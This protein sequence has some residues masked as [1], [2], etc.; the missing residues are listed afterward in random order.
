M[1]MY[2]GYILAQFNKVKHSICNLFSLY[3]LQDVIQNAL[4]VVI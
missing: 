3:Q 2:N 4:S 1:Y